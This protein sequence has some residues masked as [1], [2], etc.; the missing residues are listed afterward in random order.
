MHNEDSRSA[1]ARARSLLAFILTLRFTMPGR[2]Q[3]TLASVLFDGI[4]APIVSAQAA[5]TVVIVP[6]A[7]L[8]PSTTSG[9][10]ALAIAVGST[11]SQ[12]VNI[13]V[14]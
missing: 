8:D 5:Q 3:T 10:A 7:L 2:A 14:Q 12:T 11:F 6:Y 4:P 1:S 13:Y 9:A